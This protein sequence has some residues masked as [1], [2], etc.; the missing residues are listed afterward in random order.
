MKILLIAVIVGLCLDLYSQDSNSKQIRL[1]QNF[2]ENW[3]FAKGDFADAFKPDYNDINWLHI[4]LPHD[5]RIFE[6]VDSSS[7][8]GMEQGFFPGAVVWYR[9]KFNLPTSEKGKQVIIQFD[10]VYMN[11]DYWINGN[12][13][14]NRASGYVSFWYNI[15]PY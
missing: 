6:T 3:F 14:G 13:I 5:F 4:N 2:D 9:K 7:I 10:G 15:T 11:S 12:Y 8:A 1:K